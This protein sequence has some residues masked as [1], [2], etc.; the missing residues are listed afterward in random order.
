MAGLSA[1]SAGRVDFQVGL[2]S[3]RFKRCHV[4]HSNFAPWP[5]QDMPRV[6]WVPYII[7][8][9]HVDQSLYATWTNKEQPHKQARG[10]HVAAG[11]TSIS[12]KFLG[13]VNGSNRVNELTHYVAQLDHATWPSQ[14]LPC[15]SGS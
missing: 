7:F 4:S 10:Y 15:G 3:Q 5:N 1:M 2:S 9:Q 8:G 14:R 12:N 6:M 13:Q 11:P